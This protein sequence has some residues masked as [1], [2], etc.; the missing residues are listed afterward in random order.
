MPVKIIDIIVPSVFNPYVVERS[1]ELTKFIMGGIVSNDASLDALAKTGGSIINMPFWQDLTGDDEVLSDNSALTPAKIGTGTDKAVLLM[2]GKAW[3]VN[4]LAKALS[5]DDPL[6]VIVDKVAEFWA[7]KRQAVLMSSLKGVMA[8]NLTSDG[9]DMQVD[10]S[11]ATNA[12]VLDATK[13]NADTFIEAQST[14]GDTSTELSGIAMHS[15]V[16]HNLK[17]VDNISFEKESMGA[18]EI[19]TYRGLRLIIDDSLPFTPAGGS[20]AA[21]TAPKYTTYLFGNGAFGLGNGEAPV[22]SETDRDSLAGEDV[23][24]TRSHYILHPR[25]VKF[26]NITVAGESPLNA[27]LALPANWTRVYDRKNVRIASIVTNG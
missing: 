3:G 5:G 7:K 2:R 22:A 24:V 1:T 16:Y 18:L 23:L 11:G 6:G 17:R 4:D 25:G 27:E 8:D 15:S 12:D 19:K 26:N 9:G 20:T 10:V 21:S 14:F 13:F